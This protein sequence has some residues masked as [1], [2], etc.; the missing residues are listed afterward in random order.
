MIKKNTHSFLIAVL[1]LDVVTAFLIYL[2]MKEP[3]SSRNLYN[4]GEESGTSDT[5]LLQ[6]RL[7]RDLV[8]PNLHK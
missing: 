8:H 5:M 6:Y 2:V 1:A 4:E 7:S 3:I